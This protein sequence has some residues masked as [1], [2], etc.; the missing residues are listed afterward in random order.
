M[1]LRFYN[2]L[3]DKISDRIYKEVFRQN[4]LIYQLVRSKNKEKRMND[5]LNRL[6]KNVIFNEYYNYEYKKC[7]L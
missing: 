4:E 3:A 1:D 2:E 6:K 5:F 7:T